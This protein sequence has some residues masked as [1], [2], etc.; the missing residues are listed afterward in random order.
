MKGFELPS[1][2]PVVVK[3][4]ECTVRNEGTTTGINMFG[5]W[6]SF[7]RLIERGYDVDN[8]TRVLL[9]LNKS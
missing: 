7:S 2:S 9:F 1:L 3:S 5:G 8:Q 6:L 4:K